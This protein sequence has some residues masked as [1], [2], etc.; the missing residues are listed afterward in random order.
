MKLFNP[1]TRLTGQHNRKLYAAYE[2][3]YTAVDFAAALLFLIG[4][5]LFFRD[6]TQTA[7]TWLFVVGSVFFALKPSIRLARE[8]H[9]W[10]AGDLDTLAQREEE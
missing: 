1:K 10:R 5:I 6:S 9:Y 8:V 7:G 3:A 2:I 4:S